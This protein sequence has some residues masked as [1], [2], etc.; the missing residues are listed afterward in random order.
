MCLIRF[1]YDTISLFHGYTRQ[2]TTI[3]AR[4]WDMHI[5]C[6]IF[7]DWLQC[8]C[9]LLLSVF[10]F[11]ILSFCRIFSVHSECFVQC[12][13]IILS[14]TK[15]DERATHSTC[16]HNRH[17]LN[18][19][20]PFYCSDVVYL[21]MGLDAFIQ[22]FYLLF[23]SLHTFQMCVYIV[24]SSLHLIKSYLLPRHTFAVCELR[25]GLFLYWGKIYVYE[26]GYKRINVTIKY[27]DITSFIRMQ[28]VQNKQQS[29]IACHLAQFGVD[30]N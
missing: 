24:W 30:I 6:A 25:A 10:L 23:S 14:R 22:S 4:R 20:V 12:A 21:E 19:C 29:Q 15:H 1:T 17:K 9:S 7:V 8:S 13:H 18:R 3:R 16:W 28:S 2:T 11:L 5:F 26:Y 27:G